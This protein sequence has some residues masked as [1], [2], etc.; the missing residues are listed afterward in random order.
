MKAKPKERIS[1]IFPRLTAKVY[2]YGLVRIRLLWQGGEQVFPFY[3]SL[4]ER[5]VPGVEFSHPIR[6][7]KPELLPVLVLHGHHFGLS[8]S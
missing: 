4:Q 2:W 5:C 7:W 1:N 6:R 3:M 8:S